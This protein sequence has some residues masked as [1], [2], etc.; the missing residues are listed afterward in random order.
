MKRIE[1]ILFAQWL[2]VLIL[3]TAG[4]SAAP[5]YPKIDSP[6]TDSAHL[7]TQEQA[8][9]L[10]QRLE[11]FEQNSSYVFYVVTVESLQD[12]TVELYARTLM[13]QLHT[14]TPVNLLLLVAK[15]EHKVRIQL[16][17]KLQEVLQYYNKKM[18]ID[19]EIVPY[20]KA[21]DYAAGISHGVDELIR[22]VQT[23]SQSEVQ[24]A[25][26][27]FGD[28]LQKSF[29]I[30]IGGVIALFLM[31]RLLPV[32]DAFYRSAIA[33]VVFAIGALLLYKSIKMMFSTFAVVFL[34][35]F[36]VLPVMVGSSWYDTFDGSG[37]GGGGDSDGA[38]GEW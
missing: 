16:D 6:V 29:A 5:I 19:T 21:G 8:E 30:L 10:R 37:G 14:H 4:V 12:Q 22:A 36:F 33:A 32:E 25:T 7:L 24:E 20:F 27:T 38:S 9:A 31:Y 18:V 13:K 26:E 35:M 17:K 28:A 15:K 1:H 34:L 23:F 11:S 3:L 2:M